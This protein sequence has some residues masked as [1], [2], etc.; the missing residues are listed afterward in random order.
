L[1]TTPLSVPPILAP[2]S[3]LPADEPNPPKKRR[4]RVVDF[5]EPEELSLFWQYVYRLRGRAGAIVAFDMAGLVSPALYP[6]DIRAWII[7]LAFLT[8]LVFQAA[9]LYRPRLNLSVMDELPMLLNRTLF[10]TLVVG[11]AVAGTQGTDA[12]DQYWRLAPF[13]AVGVLVGRSVIFR[14]IAVARTRRKIQ[15]NAIILGGGVIGSQIATTLN[16]HPEYGLKSIGFIDDDPLVA[17]MSPELPIIGAAHDL[18]QIIREQHVSVLIVAFSSGSAAGMIDSIRRTE[19]A[20]VEVFVVPRLFEVHGSGQVSDN[21]GAIP[22]VRLPRLRLNSGTWAIKRLFDV[23]VSGIALVALLP[24]LVLVGLAVRLEGGPGIFFRQVRIGVKGEEFAL[25]KFRSMR[26]V[27]ET[28][29]QTNWNIANDDRVGPI[30]KILRRSSID[31]LPQLWNIL[32]GDMSLVGPRPERPHFVERFGKEHPRYIDRHRVPVG[33]TGL[34]Q[35]SGLR[36]DTSISDRAR[37]DNYYIENWSLWLDIRII[38]G[39]VKEVVFA[40]GR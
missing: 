32:K 28:E 11:A 7:T 3:S 10:T 39:T 18:E 34:A 24:M 26:P 38:F 30:G 19:A 17:G 9:G 33:L 14:I 16:E 1:E 35:I 15:H 5:R 23:V 8:I 27:D 40:K 12:F 20:N 21:I 36:G 4:L 25:F 2:S 13:A 29:S 37:Y 6:S 22:V 31:E